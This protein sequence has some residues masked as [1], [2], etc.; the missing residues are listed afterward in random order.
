M[1]TWK[2]FQH[3]LLDRFSPLDEKRVPPS[4][5]VAAIP[6][7][8]SNMGSRM[9]ELETA[10]ESFKMS[11]GQIEQAL[12][13]FEGRVGNSIELVR[14]G[15]PGPTNRVAELETRPWSQK[16]PIAQI[17]AASSNATTSR[18]PFPSRRRGRVK[19]VETGTQSVTY[20][21]YGDAPY[22]MLAASASWSDALL[23]EPDNVSVSSFVFYSL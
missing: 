23:F 12:A 13:G 2:A 4:A 11:I 17:P 18:A 19:V 8:A 14:K 10:V 5:P 9:I 6:S 15:Q 7:A 22:F 3:V 20:L 21:M 1:A 16:T